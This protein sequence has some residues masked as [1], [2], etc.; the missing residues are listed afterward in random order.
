MKQF[1][2]LYS[3]RHAIVSGTYEPTIEET[4][5]S[6]SQDDDDD[7]S[8]SFKSP[9]ST[10]EGDIVEESQNDNLT[11]NVPVGIP[12]FWLTVLKH[13]P[14]ISD[15][16]RQSDLA[17]LYHLIDLRSIPIEENGK[18]GFQLEFEF[19]TNNFFTNNILY[20]RYFMDYDVKN[21][22]P[23]SY[24]GP[25]V[26]YS[27]G[28]HIDWRPNKNVMVQNCL[29]KYQNK[30]KIENTYSFP[31]YQVSAMGVTTSTSSSTLSLNDES[32]FQF[33]SISNQDLSRK[34]SDPTFEQKILE[35]Y[36]IGQYIKERVIPRAVTYFTGEALESDGDSDDVGG[37]GGYY[38]IDED[39]DFG[40]EEHQEVSEQV[41][42]ENDV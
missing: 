12:G 24:D 3:Q 35:D 36:D 2:K 10:N 32:F 40:A 15:L 14:L 26:N 11:K 4:E 21:D 23:F 42:R 20:K 31:Q 13:S 28:C 25:E 38:D 1:E 16:I 27:E 37:D 41:T 9:K 7:L 6:L 19:E 5:F 39:D 30:P 34:T 18:S 22:N 29:K 8:L 33:F 17:V